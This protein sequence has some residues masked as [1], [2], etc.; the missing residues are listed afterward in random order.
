MLCDVPRQSQR[1]AV[2]RLR[3]ERPAAQEQQVSGRREERAAD[4]H[5]G[6]ESGSS[7]PAS[8]HRGPNGSLLII[9]KRKRGHRA[10]TEAIGGLFVPKLAQSW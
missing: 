10:E 4:S 1:A 8:R 9:E 6:W 5:R 3:H 7:C 2:E